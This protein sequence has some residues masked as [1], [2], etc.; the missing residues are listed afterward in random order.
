MKTNGPTNGKVN[1]VAFVLVLLTTMLSSAQ[2]VIQMPPSFPPA[3][4]S[5][6][7]GP[8]FYVYEYVSDSW[9]YP[10]CTLPANSLITLTHELGTING[11]TTKC[12]SQIRYAARGRS[13]VCEGLTT[14]INW[15]EVENCLSQPP[16][17]SPD[18]SGNTF[19]AAYG[20]LQYYALDN[21]V[22]TVTSGPGYE[23]KTWKS[24][25]FSDYYL[26]SSGVCSP[27]G[28]NN[29]VEGW[30]AYYRIEL[31]LSQGVSPPSLGALP[32]FAISLEKPDN[33]PIVSIK[34]G[35]DAG[36][37]Y[38]GG[39]YNGS[40]KVERTGSTASSLTVLLG[41]SGTASPPGS[42]GGSD[43]QILVGGVVGQYTSVVIPAG[44]SSVTLVVRPFYDP[45]DPTES[46]I[47][48]LQPSSAYSIHVPPL[49]SSTIQIFN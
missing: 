32:A 42:S 10:G 33:L 3:P 40:F 43:Y 41:W 37:N 36:D 6:A 47:C 39:V 29:Y 49:H 45:Y 28:I 7:T 13:R 20:L 27:C 9:A 1:F 12:R 30:S 25:D 17:Y 8:V 18:A 4:P 21:A 38:Y 34:K 15:N 16:Q 48:A 26:N 24:P 23:L 35:G 14:D 44:H 11:I 22:Y 31:T 5:S 19:H 46:V 2:L